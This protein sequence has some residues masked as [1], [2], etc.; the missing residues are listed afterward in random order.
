MGVREQT[1]LLALPF[2][3][4]IGF[5]RK[6]PY[7]C[8]CKH[9]YVYMYVEEYKMS[10]QWV[11][12][13]FQCS[14]CLNLSV[15]STYRISEFL[16]Q[17]GWLASLKPHLLFCLWTL[18]L[19]VGPSFPKKTPR[20][21]WL[22]LWQHSHHS[23]VTETNRYCVNPGQ[24][25]VA[26]QGEAGIQPPPST[27]GSACLSH[28]SSLSLLFMRRPG[29]GS[30]VNALGYLI[31]SAD[32]QADVLSVIAPSDAKTKG[33]RKAWRKY[34]ETQEAREMKER[35]EIRWHISSRTQMI[36]Q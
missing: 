18:S 15:S 33:K 24:E 4:N 19:N 23:S 14:F 9:V 13:H 35:V 2:P 16:A 32:T 34:L 26:C 5:H 3:W 36:C 11:Y 1:G 8:V 25:K 30:K 27:P 12:T 22:F 10:M 28:I 21:L 20:T 17:A 6:S 31:H 7:I 29:K